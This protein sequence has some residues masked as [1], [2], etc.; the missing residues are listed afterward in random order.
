MSVEATCASDMTETETD[1]TDFYFHDLS[2]SFEPSRTDATRIYDWMNRTKI[3]GGMIRMRFVWH[4]EIGMKMAGVAFRFRNVIATIRMPYPHRSYFVNVIMNL[5]DRSTSKF[6]T[7]PRTP[8]FTE[9]TIIGGRPC[10]SFSSMTT[11]D[12][13]ILRDSLPLQDDARH[14]LSRFCKTI[15][16]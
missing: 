14:V 5:F 12:R 9:L 10:V 15:L 6:F 3:T 16:D 2:I 13:L 4:H 8:I 11:I 7:P 1:T